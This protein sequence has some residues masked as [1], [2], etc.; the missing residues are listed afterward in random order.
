MSYPASCNFHDFFMPLVLHSGSASPV[1]FSRSV[2]AARCDNGQRDAI[3][4]QNYI[5][6]DSDE[7]AQ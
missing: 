4:L 6:G 1:R 2:A 3:H 7:K 5:R